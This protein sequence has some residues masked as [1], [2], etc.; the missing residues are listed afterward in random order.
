MIVEVVAVGTELLLGQV[1]NSNAA[2]IGARLAEAGLDTN[3]QQTVGDNLERIES[4]IRLAMSRS[5]AVIITGGIGPTADDITREAICAATGRVMLHSEEYAGALRRRWE[6]LGRVLP[7]SNLRQADYPEGAEMLENPKGTA[8]GLALDH[9]GVWLFAV[10]GVPQE[11]IH[12]LDAEII[13]RLR[14]RA[15]LDRVVRSRIIRTWGLPESKVGEMLDDLFHAGTNPSIAFLASAGEIKVRITAAG[16]AGPEIDELIAPVEAVVRERLGPAVFGADEQTIETVLHDLLRARTWT[17]GTAE[18]ATAGLV[19]VRLTSLP[20]ASE[21]FRGGI[22]AYA[23]DLKRDLLGVEASAVVTEAA[24][25]EMALGARS[26]LGCDVGV[27]VTGSA[28]PEAQ[29]EPPGTMIVAVATP[30]SVRARTLR[31]PG[32]RERVRTY[33]ATAALH[34]TRLAVAGDWWT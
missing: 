30:E 34:L 12:L 10:P 27:A 7:I 28:G 14:S 19:A 6:E 8:P 20:G 13:P 9:D 18:S 4:A 16:A 32:D 11:M 29:E 1:I 22:V 23:T 24:A 33:T 21:L 5:D 26:R 31:L 3:V 17:I 25:I 15:G 2:T